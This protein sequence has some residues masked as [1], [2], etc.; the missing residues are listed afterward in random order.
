MD[1]SAALREKEAEIL[2]ENC[3]T[4]TRI[5]REIVHMAFCDPASICDET[6]RLR[7]L[8][9]LLCAVRHALPAIDIIACAAR[10][11]PK[12]PP[13]YRSVCNFLIRYVRR[14]YELR[15]VSHLDLE[16]AR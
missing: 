1:I 11:V 14:T 2:E 4:V 16:A 10:S 12:P 13:P 3:A 5:V 15:I 7:S 9:A 8:I 6:S